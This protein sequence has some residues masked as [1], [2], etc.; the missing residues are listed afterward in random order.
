MKDFKPLDFTKLCLD[1]QVKIVTVKE[2]ALPV[3]S[4]KIPYV[5]LSISLVALAGAVIYYNNLL[6]RREKEL[7]RLQKHF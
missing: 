3:K 7:K 4:S 6:S 1:E 5:L 2:P